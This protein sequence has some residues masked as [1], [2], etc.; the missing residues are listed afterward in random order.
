M[1]LLKKIKMYQEKEEKA[2]RYNEG[3][4][5]WN[6]IDFKSLE[7]LVKTLMYG[8]NKYTKNGVSGADNWKKGMDPKKI[9]DS[10]LR[11]VTAL[12]DGEEVDPESGELHVGA[13]FANALFYSYYTYTEEGKSKIIKE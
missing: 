6:L 11:H 1:N 9:L 10:L 5:E 2:L 12:S 13:I 7:P 3:K 4:L 8:K